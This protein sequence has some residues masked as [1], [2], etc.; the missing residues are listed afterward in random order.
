M[1][2]IPFEPQRAIDGSRTCGAAALSMVYG[3]LG[4]PCDQFEVWERVAE[5]IRPGVKATRAHRLALDACNRGFAAATLQAEDPPELLAC[6]MNTDARVILN[7]RIDSTSRLGH[8]SVL[9]RFDGNEI[10]LHDPHL[11]PNRVLPWSE[12]AEL[13]C[14]T[15]GECEI[16]GHVA[17]AVGVC[18]TKRR[19]CS[20]CGH[21][22]PDSVLCPQCGR[23][24]P[25]G[26]AGVIRCTMGG[27][28]ECHWKRLFC[29]HCDWAIRPGQVG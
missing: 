2:P 25:T 4:A 8:Y 11:G 5:E 27:C 9:L 28:R 26:P 20:M 21:E 22:P 12:F 16:V 17:V 14:P 13:W 29:P 7:H 24:I 3:A 18:P 19:I 6:M 1:I 15:P 10:E 23:P